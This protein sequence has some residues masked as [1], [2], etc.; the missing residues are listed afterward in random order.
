MEEFEEKVEEVEEIDDKSWLLTIIKEY[1]NVKKAFDN[2]VVKQETS[3]EE[4]EKDD[5]TVDM[6]R[7][8]AWRCLSGVGRDDFQKCLNIFAAC[9]LFYASNQK[10]KIHDIFGPQR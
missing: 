5:E 9:L 6:C 2:E 10:N 8:Q 3:K 7:V 4:D 1:A